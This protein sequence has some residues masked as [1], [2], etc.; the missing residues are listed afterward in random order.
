MVYLPVPLLFRLPVGT[1]GVSF[2]GSVQT[3]GGVPCYLEK[4]DGQTTRATWNWLQRIDLPEPV[5]E[6]AVTTGTL[7]SPVQNF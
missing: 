7:I 3:T 6:V 1:P 4:S 5:I 2:A